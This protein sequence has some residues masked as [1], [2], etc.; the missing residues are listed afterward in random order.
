MSSPFRVFVYA[1]VAAVLAAPIAAVE[2]ASTPPV[3]PLGLDAYLQWEKWPLQRLGVRSYMRSTYDRSGG[4]QSA[5]ASHY[6]YQE[7]EDFNVALDELGPG[8]LYFKRTNHWHGSPW[9]Y[10]VDG[11]DHIVQES[12]TADPLNPVA[13]SVFLP[14]APFPNPLTWTWS[15]TRGADLMWVPIMFEQQLRI[16]Y[17]RTHYG[18]GYFILHKLLPGIALSRPLRSWSI[19]EIPDPAVLDLINRSG[20]D[21]APA[22]TLI[23]E[24]GDLS[25]AAGGTLPVA[26][27]QGPA[28]LRALKF[29]LPLD[30]ALDLERVRLR[31]TWDGRAQPSVDAPLC[32]FFG[33]GTFYNR[34]GREWLV[35]AFPVS[36]RQTADELQLACYFPMPF[37]REARIE[38]ADVPASEAEIGYEIRAEH[39]DGPSNHVG[40]F[41]ATYR[42]HPDPEPGVDLVY[43]DTREVEGGGDWTGAFVGSSFIFSHHAILGT[44]EGDPRFFFDESQ[45]PSYGTGTEEWGGGGDYWGGRTMTLPFAG[46]PVG[47]PNPD[48]A[49]NDRDRIESAYRFLLADLMPFGKRAIIRNEHGALN[50]S[51]E[52]YESVVYWYGLPGASLVRTD[53]LDVGDPA[54]E[55]AH[56]Y[57]SPDA[58]APYR[59]SSRYE[60]GPTA[61]ELTAPNRPEAN[62]A[63][64]AEF[65]F[66]L[67]AAGE[68]SL[69]VHGRA[70]RPFVTSD[71]FWVQFD[72]E[73]GTPAF[74]AA[75]NGINGLGNWL[76]GHPGELDYRWSSG[77][78]NA[79]PQVMRFAEPGTHTLRIQP[80][81][82]GHFLDEIR[83]T[84]VNAV[85]LNDQPADALAEAAVAAAAVVLRAED[86]RTLAGAYRLLD[87]RGARAGKALYIPSETR[88]VVPVQTKD[89]RRTDGTSEFTL[90]IDPD[91]H[92]VMLR[93]TLDYQYPNQRARIWIAAVGEDGN[94]GDW[95]EA[96]VWYEAGADTHLYSDPPGELDPTRKTLQTSGR[97]FRDSEFLIPL[98]LTR[99]QSA[100]RVRAEFWPLERSLWPGQEFPHRTTWTELEY[101]AWSY[102]MPP[103]PFANDD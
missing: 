103:D 86:A 44:L 62:P 31:I 61:V 29:T 38:L 12:S 2:P 89:G 97:R 32:L 64:Y 80:R 67:P 63:S 47:A 55:A 37:F 13:D 10:E 19:Q 82:R 73:I 7:A 98:E 56:D 94:P 45:T 88:E 52:H 18:T 90:R 48:A 68:Y 84:P 41:H 95:R 11:T 24:A 92:G 79:V 26:Q 99:G 71:A 46:H 33:A 69:W 78:P 39:Y 101:Q 5:D 22:D 65:S 9:H 93:R 72:G 81:H 6:L 51:R 59:F 54:D 27:I 50:D 35:K 1:L 8:V 15:V 14:E 23:Q 16:A 40:Y 17:S 21:I 53:V 49:H 30:R 28:T 20:T 34:D 58:T 42:D 83:L 87:D 100:I 77:M 60:W 4:N 25:L 102:V 3:V 36:I 85:P 43:L 91:N 96:G 66:H 75:A 57:V 74:T 76:D 70:E